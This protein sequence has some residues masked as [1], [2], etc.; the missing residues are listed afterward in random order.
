M[1]LTDFVRF[2]LADFLRLLD[3][4]FGFDD[5]LNFSN[6]LRSFSELESSADDALE[7][8]AEDEELDDD[9]PEDELVELF[10]GFTKAIE[11]FFLC[12]IILCFRSLRSFE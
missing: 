9:D 4:F 6:S 1:F 5:D 10:F 12:F 8:D 11:D 2:M 3:F 7:L